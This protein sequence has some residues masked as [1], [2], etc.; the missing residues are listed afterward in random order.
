MAYPD[1]AESSYSCPRIGFENRLKTLSG[2]TQINVPHPK[3]QGLFEIQYETLSPEELA[4]LRDYH[5][6]NRSNSFNFFDRLSLPWFAL[7]VGTG[8]GA[9]TTF[10]LPAL[11]ITGLIVKVA[12]VVKTAGVHFNVSVATGS[13]GEDRIIFTAGNIPTLGQAITMDVTRARR[14]FRVL[15]VDAQFSASW[16]EADVFSASVALEEDL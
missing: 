11:S 5:E 7:A 13:E 12:G 16:V 15:Y 14:R 1:I 2:S 6:A 8:D 4:T 9:T 10:T 3:I